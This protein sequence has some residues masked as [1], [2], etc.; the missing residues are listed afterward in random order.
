[1]NELGCSIIAVESIKADGKNQR[2]DK[3]I[4]ATENTENK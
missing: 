4:I 1:V 2:V 3:T